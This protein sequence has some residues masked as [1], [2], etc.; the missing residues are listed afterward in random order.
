MKKKTTNKVVFRV[1]KSHKRA[2]T[3][4]YKSIQETSNCDYVTVCERFNR[5][6]LVHVYMPR[7]L[8]SICMYVL[9]IHNKHKY[10]A[11]AGMCSCVYVCV[12]VLLPSVA[13][14]AFVY[15]CAMLLLLLP[16]LCGCCFLCIAIRNT[17]N[18]RTKS[19]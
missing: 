2:D 3:A 18:R 10:T 11:Y 4:R 13:V 1:E 9:I 14:I 17:F 6:Y 12:S 16:L 15:M 5:Q 8:W 7:I 19:K